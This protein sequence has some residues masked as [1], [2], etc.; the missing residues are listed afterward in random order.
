[1]KKSIQKLTSTALLAK[2]RRAAEK[3][4]YLDTTHAT[5][6]KSQRKILRSEMEYVLE[7]GW[8]EKKKD[9][10]DEFYQV[11]NYAIRGKTID[12]R[13]LRIIVSFENKMLI[14]TAIDLTK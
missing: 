13:E 5:L 8:H 9:T 12:E 2:V 4:D 6:R 3:G 7:T 10:L 14:I 1:M 11:W